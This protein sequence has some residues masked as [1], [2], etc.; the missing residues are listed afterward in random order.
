LAIEHVLLA[1]E[2]KE[3]WTIE[4]VFAQLHYCC[5]GSWRRK[6]SLN[7]SKPAKYWQGWSF[8]SPE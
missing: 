6:L 8:S 7:S 3:Y 1:P 4:P 5:L 2:R